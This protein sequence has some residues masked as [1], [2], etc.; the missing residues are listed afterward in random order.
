MENL[1]IRS[2]EILVRKDNNHNDLFATVFT[3]RGHFCL[4]YIS[5]GWMLEA[6]ES[7]RPN[8][9]AIHYGK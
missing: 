2:I 4:S 1:E 8:R 9:L 5:W 7:L 6:I 3:N